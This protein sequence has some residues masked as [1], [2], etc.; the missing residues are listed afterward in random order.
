MLKTHIAV[1]D[2]LANLQLFKDLD[3]GA[4]K[5]LA[6]SATE[7]A[8][9]REAVV[10]RRGDP[11]RGLHVVVVGQIKLSLETDRGDEKVV[12]LLGP[13]KSFGEAPMFL[14]EPHI[15]TAAAIADSR[16]LH[17]AKEAVL[18]EAAR[19]AGFALR[20]IGHL[21]RRLYQWIG[22]L[23]SYTLRSGMERVID[24]LLRP[25]FE[26]VHDGVLRVTL[27]AKKGIIASRL[28][29]TQEHFSRILHELMARKLI[30][31]DGRTVYISDAKRLRT[32]C[33]D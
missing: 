21:S 22:E 27:P 9:P 33:I 31:V 24:Y 30:D 17:I 1:E 4:L 28:N 5:R 2:F 15:V 12:E 20:V 8:V 19:N 29:L 11:C 10:Y 6:A 14:G 7:I 18:D 16:L 25:E 3:N 23:E 32:Q 26:S 13:G